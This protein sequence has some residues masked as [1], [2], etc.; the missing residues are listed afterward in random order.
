MNRYDTLAALV[1][2]TV[3]GLAGFGLLLAGTAP[4]GGGAMA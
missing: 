2:A 4:G 1:W 3:V